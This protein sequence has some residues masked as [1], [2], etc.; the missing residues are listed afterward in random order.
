MEENPYQSPSIEAKVVGVVSGQRVDLRR[1]AVYQKGILFC[2]LF[3]FFAVA[4]QFLLPES[5]Q[6]LVVLSVVVIGLTGAVF[7]FML[8]TK[9]YGTGQ[10]VLLGILTF[11]PCIGLIALVVVNGKATKILQHNDIKVGLL[12]ARMSDFDRR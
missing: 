5:L 2:I 3:Y 4:G 1:V 10:G 7:V 8:A 6:L 11:I 9:I 12:G